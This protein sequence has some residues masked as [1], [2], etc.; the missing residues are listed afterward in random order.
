MNDLRLILDFDVYCNMNFHTRDGFF[1]SR[2]ISDCQVHLVADAPQIPCVFLSSFINREPK[3]L[4]RGRA[5]SL[6][7]EGGNNG[8][9]NKRERG[10][11]IDKC[12]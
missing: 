3:I 2:Q 6:T 7:D 1:I 8:T 5:E 9:K 4:S 11:K 12:Q 10:M